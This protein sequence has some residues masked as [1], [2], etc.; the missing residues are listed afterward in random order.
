[1][2]AL[3]KPFRGFTLIEL[4]VVI[5]IV[6]VLAAL[7]LPALARAKEQARRVKCIS[8]L[9]QISLAVKD[10]ALD[11]DWKNPW[12]AAVSDG[13]TFGSS[14]GMAWKNFSAVSNELAAPQVLVCPSDTGTKLMAGT[15]PEF[16]AAGY[17]SNALSFFVGLDGYEQMPVAMLA[18]DRNITGGV[19]DKCGSVAAAPG[20]KASEYKAG[21]A[22]IRW[23]NSV[24]GVSGD[25]AF[26]DGSVQRANRRELQEIVTT[27]Y[28]LLSDGT[29]RNAAGSKTSNHLLP[30]R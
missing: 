24:H 13:G 1:M 23:S 28:R 4:L 7:L 25:I 10:F 14:A 8:N 20:V 16:M 26:T 9:K 5:A 27:S 3:P 11:H 22:S 12:H 17:Q 2:K 30:P 29:I 21:N 18:G 19:S 6:V 15:W